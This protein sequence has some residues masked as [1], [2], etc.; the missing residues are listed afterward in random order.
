MWVPITEDWQRAS[1]DCRYAIAAKSSYEHTI[2]LVVST[3]QLYGDIVYFAMV[4][5][6]GVEICLPNPVYYWF[7]YIFMNGIWVVLPGLIFVRSWTAISEAFGSRKTKTA[8]PLGL[9]PWFHMPFFI[10]FFNQNKI[11]IAKDRHN[12]VCGLV[13]G[14][15]NSTHN[16]DPWIQLGIASSHY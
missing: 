10:I 9:N 5:L 4:S 11:V 14:I 1:Y 2:Q 6:V 3:G 15:S 7:Y 16:F 12:Q 8:W 13:V